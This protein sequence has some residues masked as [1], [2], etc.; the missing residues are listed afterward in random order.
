M[1]NIN[2]DGKFEE[3]RPGFEPGACGLRDRRSTRLSYRGRVL[4][5]EEP[6]FLRCSEI[7]I[8]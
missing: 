1:S 7:A 3:P 8:E 6:L 2:T 5:S 4:T